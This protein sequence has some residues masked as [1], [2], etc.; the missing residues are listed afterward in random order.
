MTSKPELWWQDIK[1]YHHNRPDIAFI[2]QEHEKMVTRDTL[3]KAKKGIVVMKRHP[4]HF[5]SSNPHDKWESQQ[6]TAGWN[7]AI[8]QI[9]SH[10]SSIQNGDDM[11]EV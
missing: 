11:K 1:Y 6:A 10:L 5:E 2:L 9:L 4:T 3:E 7:D 8:E